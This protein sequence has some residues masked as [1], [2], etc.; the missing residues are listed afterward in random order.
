MTKKLTMRITKKSS[1]K[2]SDLDSSDGC[3]KKHLNNKRG[4][5]SGRKFRGVRK[6]IEV[7]EE[8]DEEGVSFFVSHIPSGNIVHKLS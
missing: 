4:K 5:L 1:K 2:T 8:I 3:D 7:S 6:Y